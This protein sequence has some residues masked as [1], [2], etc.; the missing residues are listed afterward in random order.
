MAAVT[1]VHLQWNY[2]NLAQKYNNVYLMLYVLNVWHN[3]DGLVEDCSISSAIALEILQSCTKSSM[4]SFP[5]LSGRLWYLPL[6]HTGDTT[7]ILR[8]EK[9]KKN[10]EDMELFVKDMVRSSESWHQ[11]ILSITES[12]IVKGIYVIYIICMYNIQHCCW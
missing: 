5:W 8:F 12:C 3:G 9:K 2:C 1:P 10:A 6:Y 4:W 7:V 11:K